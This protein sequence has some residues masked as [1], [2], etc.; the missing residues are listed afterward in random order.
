[1]GVGKRSP[2]RAP[3]MGALQFRVRVVLRA[4]A[5]TM[6]LWLVVAGFVKVGG[7]MGSSTLEPQE[8]GQKELGLAAKS[9][10]KVAEFGS[11][12]PG[13]VNYMSERR[14]PRGADPIHNRRARNSRRNPGKP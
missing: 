4:V 10:E 11:R 9:K 2:K 6:V 12:L 5:S 1:M 8:V 13:L 14:V 3:K 7:E